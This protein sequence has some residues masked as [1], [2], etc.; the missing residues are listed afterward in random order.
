MDALPLSAAPAG[1]GFTTR[2]AM[3]VIAV[4]LQTKL[5][6]PYKVAFSLICKLRFFCSPM[7]AITVTVAPYSLSPLKIIM[8][9]AELK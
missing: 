4:I 6:S 3:E 9:V 2:S 8:L 1:K 7:C 5:L